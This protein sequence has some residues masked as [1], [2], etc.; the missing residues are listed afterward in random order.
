MI[1]P[2]NQVLYTLKQKSPMRH[3]VIARAATM[4]KVVE[5]LEAP[6]GSF[7]GNRSLGLLSLGS[8]G[9][10]LYNRQTLSATF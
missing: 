1:I 9:M 3:T 7:T 4:P 10:L 5:C 6:G 8:A 2:P